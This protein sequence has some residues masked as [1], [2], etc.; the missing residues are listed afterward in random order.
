MKVKDCPNN[1][2]FDIDYENIRRMVYFTFSASAR[3]YKIKQL[4]QYN[5]LILI[6]D[7]RSD[8]RNIFLTA[9]GNNSL[10]NVNANQD[11][12][13]MFSRVFAS[14]EKPMRFYSDS[15]LEYIKER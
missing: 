2:F 10:V 1:H 5:C 14:A 9:I 4:N 11:E 7:S 12:R 15:K 13:L 6:I 8:F 3:F